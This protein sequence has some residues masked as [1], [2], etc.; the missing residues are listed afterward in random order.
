M[1]RKPFV[2]ALSALGYIILVAS[3]MFYGSK[4]TPGPDN[5]FIAP[6]AVISLFTLSAAVMGFIFLY[7]PFVLYFDKKEKMAVDLF[8][9]TMAFFACFTIIALILLF[10]GIL[11]KR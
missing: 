10:S 4:N 5:S 8:F 7:Q 6:V 9:K 1:T 11:P 3:V 2:N